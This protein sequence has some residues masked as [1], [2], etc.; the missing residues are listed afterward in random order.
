[1]SSGIIE[2]KQLQVQITLAE[3]NLIEQLNGFFNKM[4][5]II[6]EIDGMF[7]DVFQGRLEVLKTRIMKT[8]GSNRDLRG[9]YRSILEYASRVA[10]AL[11]SSNYYFNILHISSEFLE[12]VH[13]L[14]LHLSLLHT[15]LQLNE[16]VI[17]SIQKTLNLLIDGVNKLRSALRTYI[18]FPA[19]MDEAL[20]E[21]LKTIQN[22]RVYY[23]ESYI[24][25]KKENLDTISIIIMNDVD[26]IVNSFIG[27]YEALLCLHTMKR[28]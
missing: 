11:I 22:L 23:D 6:S 1:M 10:P 12:K 16:D 17:I 3:E 14:C 21:L 18:E 9:V 19:K 20:S 26:D 2:P 5:N 4:T 8:L 24:N 27:V 25:I 28:S 13:R 15:P 7:N